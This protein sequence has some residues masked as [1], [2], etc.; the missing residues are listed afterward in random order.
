VT[1]SS[2]IAWGQFIRSVG[3]VH[4]DTGLP[5]H[6]VTPE[7]GFRL[8]VTYD[9][10]L[11]GE[12]ARVDFG[13]Y[14]ADGQRVGTYGIAF[15]VDAAGET[16]VEMR[17]PDFPLQPETYVVNVA[18]TDAT[19]TRIF[20]RIDKFARFEVLPSAD[21]HQAGMVDLDATWEVVG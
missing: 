13:I 15:P 12:P 10:D 8:R 2:T 3:M 19:N 7:Q 17:V 20:E 16:T 6:T 14:R 4:G 11:V 1:M 9:A 21:R 18:L 5:L